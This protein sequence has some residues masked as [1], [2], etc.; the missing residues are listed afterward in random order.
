MSLFQL[1][2]ADQQ[3]L[4]YGYCPIQRKEQKG[5]EKEKKEIPPPKSL[6]FHLLPKLCQFSKSWLEQRAAARGG[7]DHFPFLFVDYLC[8]RG[9]A[10][11]LNWFPQ[12]LSSF[13]FLLFR[14]V[15]HT[16]LPS[17]SSDGRGWDH[18]PDLC[19]DSPGKVEWKGT[20]GLWEHP[21]TLCASSCALTHCSSRGPVAPSW[22]E[23]DWSK[24][25]KGMDLSP[26]QRPGELLPESFFSMDDADV[27]LRT[28]LRHFLR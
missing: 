7:V 19:F 25:A 6:M 16:C 23:F 5:R 8:L 15:C 28:W 27:F 22:Q 18:S 10:R 14:A 12:A 2:T 13:L 11:Q 26:L 20:K 1:Q 24:P 21:C 4:Q 17:C 3:N 9:S